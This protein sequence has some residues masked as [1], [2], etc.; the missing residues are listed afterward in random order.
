LEQNEILK[1]E[2]RS[3]S[4]NY[5]AWGI[6]TALIVYI[7]S[8]G[9]VIFIIFKIY[10]PGPWIR[11]LFNIIYFPHMLIDKYHVPILYD[12]LSAYMKFWLG[13]AGVN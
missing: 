4:R 12:L 7:L 1:E 2:G 9:P 3:K 11:D 10:T 8:P 13:L 6:P 5:W